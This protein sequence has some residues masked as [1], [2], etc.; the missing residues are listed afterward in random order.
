MG[1]SYL[2]VL[3]V[4]ADGVACLVA[5]GVFLFFDMLANIERMSVDLSEAGRFPVL[6]PTP[7]HI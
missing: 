3:G 4:E 7:K 6:V 1:D 5:G 2:E